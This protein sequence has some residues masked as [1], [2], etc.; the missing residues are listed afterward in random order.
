MY[1]GPRA[2][3]V[4]CAGRVREKPNGRV[5][6]HCERVG[7]CILYRRAVLCS[8]LGVGGLC[9]GLVGCAAV[10]EFVKVREQEQE[11]TLDDQSAK[12]YLKKISRDREENRVAVAIQNRHAA[13]QLLKAADD[14]DSDDRRFL[15]R[16]LECWGRRIVDAQK[17]LKAHE[18][19]PA[20]RDN[21]E[22]GA[23]VVAA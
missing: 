9:V 15:E 5:R 12:D 14:Q 2:I 8:E 6:C 16:S 10:W 11:L 17:Q 13:T 1:L 7:D 21:P 20:W 4:A 3:C 18:K 23:R 22:S 19:K